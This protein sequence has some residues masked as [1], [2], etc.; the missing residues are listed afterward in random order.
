MRVWDLSPAKLCRYHLLGEH[1]E[2]HAIWSVIT[3][4]KKGYQHH[5]E[6]KRW[7]A[8]LKALYQRHELLVKELARRGYHHQSFLDAE[9]AKGKAIQDEFIDS[10]QEQIRII[11]SKNCLCKV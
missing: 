2:I 11:R 1:G 10:L 3:K 8:K 5:P 7:Q 4:K 6:V 9:L